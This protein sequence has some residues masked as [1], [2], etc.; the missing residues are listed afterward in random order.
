VTVTPTLSDP[1][2]TVKVNGVPVTSGN[3]SGA[4]SLDVG[5]N[6]ITTVVVS[7]DT[8]AT[9]I[10]TL[11]VIRDGPITVVNTLAYTNNAGPSGGLYTVATGYSTEGVDKLVVTAAGEHGFPNGVGLINS[12][13]Y[14]GQAMTMA[15]KV[16]NTQGAYKEAFVGIYYLDN[17]SQYGASGDIVVSVANA[18]S[19]GASVMSLVGTVPGVDATSSAL[20]I[21]PTLAESASI[22]TKTEYNVVV[23][24]TE[25]GP[26]NTG[27]QPFARPP[28]TQVLSYVRTPS[29]QRYTASGSGYQFVKGLANATSTFTNLSTTAATTLAASFGVA[30]PTLSWDIDGATPG[31]GG[32]TPSGNWDGTTPN[33]N[34][35]YLGTGD[36][37]NWMNGM[38]ASFAAGTDATG[39][40]TVTVD[41]TRDIGGLTFEEGTV[42]L[43]GGTALRISSFA[44]L[45]TAP[46]LTATVGTPLS[47][48]AAGR[49]LTKTGP[50]TVVLAGN[51]TYTG[52][53]AV[54]PGGGTLVLAGTNTAAT[55]G[56]SLNG[57]VARFESP[58]S[59]NGTARNIAVNLGGAAAFGPSF[60]AGNIPT[61]L[62]GR[63][64]AA[65]AGAIAADNYDTTSLDFNTP[66]LTATSLG[67]IG[68]VT[69]TGTLT[70]NGSTYRLGGGGGT[71]IM[72]NANPITG[73]GKSL[74]VNGNVTLPTANDFTGG[75][76]LNVGTLGIGNNDCLGSGSLTFNGGAI[77]SDSAT[78]RTVANALTLASDV[79][80]GDAVNKGKLTFTGP[81]SL[82]TVIR[83]FTL[84][85]DA[86]LAGSVSGAG[87]A[88]TKA[89]TN[90]LTLSG[91]N[92]YSGAT[93]VS[94]GTLVLL[95]SNNSAGTTLLSEGT[96]LQLGGG[97]NGGLAGGTLTFGALNATVLQPI[98]A[99]RKI[100]NAVSLT[101][102]A[103]VGGT[104]LISG[105]QNLEI[106]GIFT[107][108]SGGGGGRTLI[109]SLDSGKA[110]TLSGQVRLTDSGTARTQTINVTNEARITGVVTNGG[111]GVGS[112][113]KSGPGLLILANDNRYTGVT[114]AGGGVLQLNSANALPGGIGT[115]GGTNNLTFNGGV[116][117]LGAGDFTRSLDAVA[118]KTAATFT[119][120]GGWAAYVV[121]RV[122][123]LGGASATI[124]WATASTGFNGKTLILGASTATQKVTLQNPLDLD[125][126]S[127]TVQVDNGAAAVDAALSGVLSGWGGLTKTGAGTLALAA[128]N[129]Y[130]G[131]TTISGGTLA[132][133]SSGSIADTPQIEVQT[134]ATFDVSAVSGFTLGAAQTLKGKGTVIGAVAVNGTLSP[135]ASVGTLNSGSQTWNGGGAC[136]FELSSAVNSAGMDLLNLTGTLDV[137]AT[138]GTP[139]NLRLVSMADNAT[140]GLVPDFDSNT[141]YTW[142]VATA[143]G[144]I[145]SF[146]AGKFAIDASQFANAPSGAFSVAKQGNN[147]VV[148]YT[149]PVPVISSYG[150][151]TGTSFPLTF[152]GL[153]GL[154]YQVLCSTNVELP[155]ASW[156][157]LSSG[158]FG[159]GGPTS[160]NY[161]DTSATNAQQFYRIQSP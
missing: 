38:A 77:S 112:L 147:L 151:L 49:R 79:T 100:T 144:G 1:A 53:T 25:N 32:A 134:N 155:L 58:A 40:Y 88:L 73:A 124:S 111:A 87:A 76:T 74:V 56:M 46:G 9:N 154:T 80:L 82:G 24:V 59:I 116:V 132:L 63:I 27:V 84:N 61:A 91:A 141:S 142:V 86:E 103:S 105:S 122:V 20:V 131:N 10:Y 95:G 66:G 47:E 7:A 55:G 148:H 35:N 152:S 101:Y 71:L 106:S 146:D 54:S 128:A 135:G 67:A 60:G 39:A 30:I 21:I 85:S 68:N 37:T 136:Q 140:P 64:M 153:S 17:P 65:S 99:D 89:G 115:A 143:S 2:A 102:L 36:A 33:W 43:A 15:I 120:N 12:V 138:S 130:F 28:M 42:N 23:A 158:T 4:I 149:S 13:T 19:F 157:L 126:T 109:S 18:N 62:S 137:Q 110:L 94:K 93:T 156:S 16:D 90:T 107:F 31:A 133:G 75:T 150:P 22:V 108:A 161:T 14:A 50:G 139:F 127:C 26:G 159:V 123:N 11:N 83:V 145:L 92:T 119:G 3:P 5:A 8:T 70:P 72:A 118:T 51:N 113:T 6:I 34:T 44:I 114:T 41:G 125:V 121:D 104:A 69:Y 97:I 81:A 78:A 45:N 52:D 117:G 129:I 29:S 98:G 160:T 57:G 48:D 96:T